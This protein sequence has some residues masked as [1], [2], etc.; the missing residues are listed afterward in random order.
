MKELKPFL[1]SLLVVTSLFLG[2]TAYAAPNGRYEFNLWPVTDNRYEL[3]TT[4]L[5][6]FR[7]FSSYASTTQLSADSLCLN[8]DTCRTTWPTGGSGTFSWTPTSWGVSTST[9]LG[10]L[11]GFLSTASSTINSNLLITGNST[12]TNATTTAF[13][14]SSLTSAL[15]QTNANG[16]LDEYAGTTCTNQFVRVLSA[17][18]VA[19]CATVDISADTNLA[20]D[21]EVVLTGDAL[22][23]ASTIARDTELPVGANPTGTIGLTAVNGVATTFLRSDGAPALSQ[24]ITPTWTGAHIFDNITRSTTTSATTT[25][26]FATTASTTNFSI[27]GGTLR[28]FGTVGTALSDFCTAITGGAGLC[29]GSDDG[30]AG[31][32][33]FEIA[34]TTD[35][36]VPNLA[37]FTQTSGRTTLGSVATGTVSASGGVT[38]TAGRSAIGGSLAITCSTADTN[39]QGCLS[40]T[41]WDTFNNKQAT[42]SAT[43][44][45]TLTGA[46]I[47][48]NGLSTSS[49]PTI[50]Q[51]PYWTGVNTFGSVATGT[52]SVP[53]GL[54]IT[55]N[56]SAVGGAAVIGLDTGYVIPLQSTLD[57]KAEDATT[58]T[59]AGTANQITSS[60]GAQDISTNRTWTLSLPN[61]VIF[62]Q[63]ASTT[64]GFSSAYASSTLY[65]GA[66]LA[67]CDTTTGKLLW[68]N[69]VFSCGTD[70]NTGG[71][72]SDPFTHP[73][74]GIFA[75]TTN[76]I[77]GSSATASSTLI[78]NLNITGNSTTTQATTTNFFSTVLTATTGYFTSIFVGVDTL[79]EY[80]SDTAGAM[81]TGN[82][83]TGGAITYQDADNTIDFVC[84]TATSGVFG[85]LASADWSIFNNKVSSTSI[86]ISSELISL[87]TDEVGTGFL[88]FNAAP[89]FTGDVGFAT[90]TGT[91]PLTSFSS[92]EP[93]FSLS[94]GAGFAQWA[95]RNAGGNLYLST[96]TVAGTAT[97][98]P[99]A[100]ELRNSGTGLGIATSTF[101]SN[102]LGLGT[103][104][105]TNGTTT[106]AAGKIQFDGYNTDGSRICI[107]V[108]STTLTIQSGACNQ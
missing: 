92:T 10:F 28:I 35:I 48:F 64:L 6:W 1:I 41:D 16:S 84:N 21:T 59:I 54:T 50:G 75:T 49:A 94:A 44:P 23:L 58:L 42:I 24:S 103:T 85:C 90:T 74:A 26:L 86:D 78:G 3:G 105:S 11:N 69:G 55:A 102:I 61:T 8:S 96:T 100:L 15:L 56:R 80:I 70:F 95:F 43:W 81:W 14:V 36:A 33:A 83:E 30:G 63:Y 38:V 18:G 93:Q 2:I 104:G 34:T 88:T 37:Y 22:S 20:G 65:H 52:I 45:I 47:G 27:G 72:G 71:G 62:P 82:T 40:D 5:R 76:F 77:I 108:V 4:T 51:M 57:A 32:S 99:A 91:W 39:T 98:T 87:V 89:N 7:F 107:F 25:N 67:S 31:T 73:S 60:A 106:I 66:G 19:T 68:T 53:T 29:D 79:A 13:A 101:S 97:S 46:A 12:T 17:L 9:T